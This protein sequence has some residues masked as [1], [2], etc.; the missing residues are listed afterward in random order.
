MNAHNETEKPWDWSQVTIYPNLW[1]W[2]QVTVLPNLGNW[3][4]DTEN[5]LNEPYNWSHITPVDETELLHA[6]LYLYGHKLY[7]IEKLMLI[8]SYTIYKYLYTKI[9]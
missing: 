1:D 9:N 6:R 5:E 8:N 7:N 4:I 2:S 3:A